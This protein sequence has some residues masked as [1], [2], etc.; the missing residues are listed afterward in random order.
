MSRFRMDHLQRARAGYDRP[1]LSPGWA[2]PPCCCQPSL[3]GSGSRWAT[4]TQLFLTKR[5]STPQM[6]G[7]GPGEPVGGL[8]PTKETPVLSEPLP[9]GRGV[10][11]LDPVSRLSPTQLAGHIWLLPINAGL[12]SESV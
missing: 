6:T 11:Y 4:H 5:Q 3:L 2:A 8:P 10:P 7:R 12:W 9:R 1:A